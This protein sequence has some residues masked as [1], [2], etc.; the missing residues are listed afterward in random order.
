MPVGAPTRSPRGCAPA[1]RSSTPSRGAA[2]RRGAQ[3]G[4]RRRGWRRPE[5]GVGPRGVGGRD[6]GDPGRGL[7]AG[8]RC[9]GR[10]GQ[11]RR[12]SCSI[13]R[14]AR[15]SSRA[16]GERVHADRRS[17][18]DMYAGWL[19]VYPIV[20]IE[21]GL[22]EDDW[23]G[24]R[25]LTER[26]GERVQ[27]VGDDLFVT[28]VD[29]LA[30]RNRDGRGQLDPHQAEPDRHR[31]GDP[32]CDRDG[33]EGRVH[34][35]HLAP[36]G[37]DR[38][39]VHRGPRRGHVAPARSRRVP[40]VD[41][42]GWPSTTA[43][44]GS[45]RSSG[46]GHYPG[47]RRCMSERLS[48]VGLSRPRGWTAPAGRLL[49]PVRAACTAS[50]TCAAAGEQADL[51]AQLDSLI[52]AHGL[53]RASVADSLA[54]DPLAIE[55]VAREESRPDPGRR[56]RVPVPFGRGRPD[57]EAGSEARAEGHDGRTLTAPSRVILAWRP[58]AGWSSLV[59]RRAHNPKVAGS[60]PAPASWSGSCP[61]TPWLTSA[62]PWWTW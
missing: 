2:Q 45:R 28:N 22:A 31:D 3:H 62:R 47:W 1:P 35:G 48:A 56:G 19:D 59:A 12:R 25:R 4:R 60:N 13:R 42:S 29:R 53:A 7:R 6:R 8:E 37:R 51:V 21:D 17:M 41:P 40:P 52:S 23:E 38:G 16:S 33:T 55:R 46:R 36:F 57:P 58:V 20:S 11:L 44:C 50:S 9:G 27:I 54:S 24:G 30:P 5:P 32:R 18:V 39:H 15:T 49:R 61:R 10:A 26:L 34:F 43:C 14:A